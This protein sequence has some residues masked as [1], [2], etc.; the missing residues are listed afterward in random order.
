MRENINNV[1]LAEKNRNDWFYSFS[2]ISQDLFQLFQLY[3]F[4]EKFKYSIEEGFT[5]HAIYCALFRENWTSCTFQSFSFSSKK[6]WISTF[7]GRIPFRR[8]PKTYP[9]TKKRPSHMFEVETMNLES[10]NCHPVYPNKATHDGG[11]SCK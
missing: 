5:A 10:M 11:T 6:I 7:A 8:P 3:Q 4:I 2:R 1:F 9:A